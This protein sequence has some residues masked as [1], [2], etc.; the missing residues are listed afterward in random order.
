MSHTNA[1]RRTKQL[2]A[3]AVLFVSIGLAVALLPMHWVESQLHVEPDGGDGSFELLLALAPVGI[4]LAL[5]AIAALRWRAR[6]DG[7]RPTAIVPGA[8]GGSS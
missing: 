1:D 8:T 4:G 3:L 7:V 5:G 2:A 6:G